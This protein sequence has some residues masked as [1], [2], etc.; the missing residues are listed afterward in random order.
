MVAAEL[1][2]RHRRGVVRVA[3]DCDWG[4]GVELEKGATRLV[5]RGILIG[6]FRI[7]GGGFDSHGAVVVDRDRANDMRSARGLLAALAGGDLRPHACGGVY[8]RRVAC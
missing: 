8:R 2:S 4:I 5:A 3:A 6:V 7:S 1:G